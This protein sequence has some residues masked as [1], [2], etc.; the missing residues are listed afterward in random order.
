MKKYTEKS[1]MKNDIL[2][3][4]KLP[5]SIIAPAGC[6]KTYTIVKILEKYHENF[7][8]I[9]ILSFTNKAATEIYERLRES[10]KDDDLAFEKIKVSTFHSYCMDLLNEYRND[11]KDKNFYEVIDPSFEIYFLEKNRNIYGNLLYNNFFKGDFLWS[12][13]RNN[14]D[15]VNKMLFEKKPGDITDSLKSEFNFRM[16][17]F[18]IT[19]KLYRSRNFT[20]YNLILRDVYKLL[21]RKD[22]REKIQKE[23]DFII[24]DEYQDTNTIQEEI[25]FY[26]LKNQ[27]ILVLGDDDQSIYRFR[28]AVPENL[29][30][31]DR[32]ILKKRSLKLHK[33][34]LYTNY[35]SKSDIINFSNKFIQKI[36]GRNEKKIK[37]VT[38]DDKKRVY[39]IKNDVKLVENIVRHLQEFVE[40]KDIA[41]MFPTLKTPFAK[42]LYQALKDSG[43][44]VSNRHQTGFFAKEEIRAFIYAIEK[45]FG[46]IP[47]LQDINDPNTSYIVRRKESYK[48][49]ILAIRQF[50][51]N[52]YEKLD[53]HLDRIK[54][55]GEISAETFIYSLFEFEPF[56][57]YL[58]M[59]DKGF[60]KS[61]TDISNFVSLFITFCNYN[62][63]QTLNPENSTFSFAF[64]WGYLFSQYKFNTIKSSEI[65]PDDAISFM[66][67]HQSKGLEFEVC[68]VSKAGEIYKKTQIDFFDKINTNNLNQ[69]PALKQENSVNDNI[70]KYYT[71]FTRARSLLF[72]FEDFSELDRTYQNPIN[73][74][75]TVDEIDFKS[76]NLT[77][78]KRDKPKMHLSYTADLKVY[79]S[80]PL[81]YFFLRKYQFSTLKN[82]KSI[83]GTKIHNIIEYI[84]RCVLKNEAFDEKFILEN[85]NEN[86][87]NHIKSYLKTGILENL[88]ASEKNVE[89]MY[90]D[91]FLQGKIDIL[92]KDNT[93]VD[94][95]TG[96]VAIIDE[97]KKQLF[98]YKKLIEKQLGKSSGQMLYFIEE[99]KF[100]RAKLNGMKNDFD[101]EKLIKKIVNEKEYPKTDDKSQCLNCPFIYYCKR[102]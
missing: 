51:E 54:N 68:F 79:E 89:Q 52:K 3:N 86:E 73:N 29:T 45:V 71:A 36:P 4:L 23:I 39:F 20:N 66:T 40:L 58:D 69:M 57:S 42:N 60:E 97:Y 38:Y 90:E 102:Y 98:V 96:K 17:I 1:E 31:F 22:V 24:V 46:K 53:G 15:I 28:G 91:V 78:K 88:K 27:N 2:E 59:R 80:C 94:I 18:E 75:Y 34:N 10:F 67:I 5:A 83:F 30:H 12:V 47:R 65:Q 35:R 14:D 95:K 99:N 72:I 50:F 37:S 43:L 82:E 33:Y 6:G 87:R 21:K 101:I 8:H 62:N 44:N 93:I 63:F 11:L 85:T 32:T 56:K 26:L 48:A 84:N 49:K 76:L 61:L 100:F 9:L 81:K 41:F 7:D 55:N 16:K 70:R 92:L 77:S 13:L 64:V 25:L 19:E 74:V